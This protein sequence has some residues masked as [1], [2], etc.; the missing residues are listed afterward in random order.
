MRNRILNKANITLLQLEKTFGVYITSLIL[1]FILLGIAAIYVTPALVPRQL[2]GG[3]AQLSINPLDFSVQNNLRF[4]IVTPLLAYCFGLR[5]SF[6]IFCPLIIAVLF[7]STIYYQLRKT[8]D[9]LESLLI[10]MIICF[11]S[12]ILFLLH[13]QGYVDVTSYLLIFLIIIFIKKPVWW[14]IFL[15][16]LLLNHD[17]N[18]FI[19]PCLLY[20]YFIQTPNKFKAILISL[21]S[22]T[23]AFIPFYFYRKYVTDHAAVEYTFQ[24][25]FNGAIENIKSLAAYFY[26]GFFYAFK[27]FWLF[28]LCAVYYYWKE[29]N[30]QQLFF[31]TFLLIGVL[32]QLLVASD[33]S[34]LIGL[35]FPMIIF[36]AIKAKEQWGTELF[37]KRTFYII[38]FNFL[39][40]Q[41]YVGQS[42]M[43]R[44]YPLPSS[45]I[46]KHFFGIET[47][48]G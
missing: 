11:S 8:H 20:L 40:P 12:P 45:L 13:F 9:A 48:V 32:G 36:S 37:I 21:L 25:Y 14:T 39:I 1:A 42:V 29:K 26:V 6:Y 15:A 17:S 34:R 46:L 4:R 47:W 38:I 24:M 10:M 22:T 27:L 18:L 30:K 31:F 28:P 41:F 35:A 19:I 16:L 2:G 23:M 44:F 43:I 33:T 3:Y 5:G 7:L